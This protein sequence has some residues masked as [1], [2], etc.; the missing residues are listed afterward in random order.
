LGKFQLNDF[1]FLS[2]LGTGTFGRVRLVKHKS[3]P[4]EAEPLAL[5]CLKKS[6]IIRL[7]QIEHVKS[8]KKILETINHPFIVNL[9]GTFQT[10]SH[11]F[12]LLDYACGGE[13]FT[14][15]RREGRFANDVAL[16]FATEIVLAFEYLHS[17]DI[18]YR[19]LKPENLL[20]DKEGHV[21]ITDFGF[22]KI[23]TDRTYTLCGT[24][25]YLAPEII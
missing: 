3:E 13:L 25:E 2:T 10:P 17:M 11:V 4:A 15:L 12:M 14:L 20:I 19:D 1:K 5:K 23:V 22:A 16:F 7:K 8:E 21:K 18:A 6:E 9:K 24:P